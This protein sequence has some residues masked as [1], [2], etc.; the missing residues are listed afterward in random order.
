MVAKVSVASGNVNT[1]ANWS[2]SGQPTSA[3]TVTITHM[4]TVPNGVTFNPGATVV[5]GTSD[6][7]RAGLDTSAGGIFRQ[8]GIVTF[9]AF[10]KMLVAGEWDTNGFTNDYTVSAG[11]DIN[12]W[13]ESVG[14]AWRIWSS[15]TL[16]AI[17]KN[18]GSAMYGR[19]ILSNGFLSNINLHFGGGYYAGAHVRVKNN[20][21]YNMGHIQTSQYTYAGDDWYWE[22]NDF[23]GCVAPVGNECALFAAQLDF[24]G[25]TLNTTKRFQH[26][27]FRYNNVTDPGIKFSDI[28]TFEPEYIYVDKVSIT[29]FQGTTNWSKIFSTAGGFGSVNYMELSDSYIAPLADN[30]HTMSPGAQNLVNVIIEAFYPLDNTDGGDH[31]IAGPLGA[32]I[33]NSIIIAGWGGVLLNALGAD[34]AGNYT[35]NHCTIVIDCHDPVYGIVARN[36]NGGQFVGTLTTRSNIVRIRSNPSL[37]ANIRVW[38]MEDPGDD[39]V[40]TMS[41]NCISGAGSNLSTIF[42]N[43]TSATK[44]YGQAGWGAGD[45]IEVDPELVDENRGLLGWGLA[46]GKT[47]HQQTVD[48]MLNGVNGYNQTTHA[49]SG[50]T[51]TSID[52]LLAYVRAGM[53]PTNLA[54]KDAG[55]DGVTMGALEWIAAA[56]STTKRVFNL[57]IGIGL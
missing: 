1:G 11:S 42:Y 4:M 53:R 36:E 29:N 17:Q 57:G 9:N 56:A 5:T 33:L 30:M 32:E 48:H 2:P 37:A 49:Q 28:T 39:Q 40:T 55:H 12:N 13:I 35:L 52:D 41:H 15:T 27:T 22:E 26:N 18:D 21:F 7:S 38:N 8:A 16:G 10:N 3:D 19:L 14:S 45:L 25:D 34:M 46:A 51:T 31:F 54:V 50:I 20:V 43:V 6:G 44:T 47:T 24:S 23:D